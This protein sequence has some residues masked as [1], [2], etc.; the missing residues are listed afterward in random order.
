M[1]VIL[2][3]SLPHAILIQ[4]TVDEYHINNLHYGYPLD[5]VYPFHVS[6]PS[7]EVM[8]TTVANLA[9]SALTRT[10][11]TYIV[12]SFIQDFYFRIHISQ[13]SIDT[14]NLIEAQQY[15]V[16]VWNAWYVAKELLEIVPLD[17]PHVDVDFDEPL[18]YTIRRLRYNTATITVNLTT[19][20]Q[21]LGLINFVF[22]DEIVFL[23]VTGIRAI[24][25]PFCPLKEFTESRE[26]YTDVITTRKTEE[27]FSHRDYPRI[28]VN[29]NFRFLNEYEYS[30]ANRIAN[31]IAG[32]PVVI[33]LWTELRYGK[34]ITAGDT[35]VSFDTSNLEIHP[36]DMVV[37]YAGV[38]KH[39]IGRIDT[40]TSQGVTLIDAVSMNFPE[41]LILVLISG[42]AQ[43]GFSFSRDPG[44]A[45]TGALQ[46]V[47]AS[48]QHNY[49]IPVLPTFQSIP[50]LDKIPVVS[51]T[52]AEGSSTVADIYDGM[53][54]N[55]FM[56]N[57]EEQARTFQQIRYVANNREEL[58]T[59]RGLFHYL[60]GRG[61]LFWYSSFHPDII[62]VEIITGNVRVTFRQLVDFPCKYIEVIGSSTSYHEVVAITKVSPTIEELSLSPPI[63]AMSY[64][65]EIRILRKMRLNSDKVEFQHDKA[66]TYITAPVIEVN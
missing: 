34:N 59:L 53:S 49:P 55:I 3:S 54:T 14:G 30:L 24:L 44:G 9:I 26:W 6:A 42:I 48:K 28:S 38:D 31:T 13:Y 58:Y 50:I 33:P 46:V 62:N 64:V 1:A 29:Y 60:K 25:W 4:G 51:G 19:Q 7:G 15:A 45:T 37:L 61:Q 65:K 18:P 11:N 63:E 40:V 43:S 2:A 5:Y 57:A 32:L 16:E 21:F 41:C 39:F 36:S 35:A 12:P 52:L 8:R 17:L 23:T 66:V 22:S 20:A 56:Y 47:T 27:R 10:I